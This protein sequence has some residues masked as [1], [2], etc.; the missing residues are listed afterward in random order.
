MDNYTYLIYGARDSK[1][2]AYHWLRYL[3]KF[4]NDDVGNRLS[5]E[6]VQALL[7]SNELSAFQRISLRQAVIDGTP[8]NE[9]VRS[10]TRPA[11][12]S[13]AVQKLLYKLKLR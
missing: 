4:I 9:R 2:C 11:V 8:T 3:N 13:D 6:D 7:N 1:G 12:R 5:D 10:V